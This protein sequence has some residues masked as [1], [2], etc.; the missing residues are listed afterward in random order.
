VWLF[1]IA[2]NLWRDRLRRRNRVP[3]AQRLGGCDPADRK[4]PPVLHLTRNEDVELAMTHLGLLPPRQQQVVYL[5]VC[6]GL[7]LRHISEVLDISYEA[8]KA[9]L[10]MGRKR[11][12]HELKDLFSEINGPAHRA[13]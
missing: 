9:S 6:E 4:D 12:R 5:H 1:R 2:A 7:C 13:R 8:A 10:A 3:V 11:L